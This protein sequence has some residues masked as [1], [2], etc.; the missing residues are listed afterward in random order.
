MGERTECE[1]I[2]KFRFRPRSRITHLHRIAIILLV[3][4][5]VIVVAVV[6]VAG[7]DVEAI[8]GQVH[9]QLVTVELRHLRD[10]PN[11][12]LQLLDAV[13]QPSQLPLL[14]LLTLSL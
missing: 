2:H 4:V 14:H 5:I 12:P 10:V 8:R 3:I 1:K 6:V 11:V 7:H 13:P 9:R